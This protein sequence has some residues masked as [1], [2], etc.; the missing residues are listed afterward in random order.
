M[1]EQAT[2]RR[3]TVQEAAEALGNSVEAVRMR[4]RRG[5]L[6]SEKEPDGRVYVY[7]DG[8]SSETKHSLDGEPS[9]LMSAKE[10]TISLLREQLAE[11][12]EAKRRADTIIAQLTQANAALASRCRNSRPAGTVQMP[13][14]R[15]KRSRKR[16]VRTTQGSAPSNTTRSSPGPS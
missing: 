9:A 15:S 16:A 5:S 14:R 11:E 6:D 2:S 10:E 13:P 4:V 12:G 7:L 8:D 3:L 1:T